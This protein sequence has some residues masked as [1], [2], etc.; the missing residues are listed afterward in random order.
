MMEY[1]NNH[2]SR[3]VLTFEQT[4]LVKIDRLNNETANYT[5]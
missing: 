3:R 2:F 5:I 1:T 4:Y